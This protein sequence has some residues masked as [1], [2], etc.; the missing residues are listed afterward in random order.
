MGTKRDN[1]ENLIMK[2]GGVFYA[3]L[4]VRGS[5]QGRV[6]PAVIISNDLNNMFSPTVQI[7]PLTS[8]TKKKELP[9]H[10]GID[11]KVLGREPQVLIEQPPSVDKA[12]LIGR[13]G[14]LPK[15][16]IRVIE[17]A[18]RIQFGFAA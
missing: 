6:R 15:E 11:G 9:V 14:S 3:D 4:P 17:T 8:K 10:V 2:R 7:I 13:K 5:V 12:V 16:T 1:T 18:I